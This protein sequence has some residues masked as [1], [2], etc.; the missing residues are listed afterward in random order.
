MDRDEPGKYGLAYILQL[1]VPTLLSE[2]AD[3]RTAG[4]ATTAQAVQAVSEPLEHS[5]GVGRLAAE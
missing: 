3:F 1:A 5:R 2:V 4:K